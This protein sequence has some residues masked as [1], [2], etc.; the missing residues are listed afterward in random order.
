MYWEA[1]ECARCIREKKTESDVLPLD[2]SLLVLEVM[3]SVLGQG[4]VEYPEHITS[5]IY[6]PDD[7]LITQNS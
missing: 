3:E 7:S 6:D 1:D 4:G 2:E 5:D